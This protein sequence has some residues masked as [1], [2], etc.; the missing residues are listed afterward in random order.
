MADEDEEME[1]VNEEEEAE[2]EM[3]FALTPADAK[4]GI[5]DFSK[6]SGERYYDRATRQL[7]IDD[8]L[9]DVETEDLHG[10]VNA[11][12]ER[13]EEFGWLQIGAGILQIPDD[14]LHPVEGTPTNLITNYGEISMTDL[15]AWENTY[16]TT[17]T[18][19]AQDT[20]M[21]YHC[22]M[23]SLTQA[24]KDKIMLWKS[25]FMIGR[26]R[27]GVLLFKL[28]VRESH[29]DSNATASTIRRQM[30]NLP[31]YMVSVGSDVQK[32]TRH[33]K[34][35]EQGLAARGEASTDLLVN[36]FTG[37]KAAEDDIFHKYVCDKEALHEEG[38]DYSSN[39]LMH[40]MLEKY[41]IIVSK[42]EWMAPTADQQKI[43][44]LESKVS[45]LVKKN[46]TDKKVI[47]KNRNGGKGNPKITQKPSWLV[48]DQKPP[49]DAMDQLRKWNG[50]DWWY[51]DKETGG[52]CPGKWRRHKPSDCQGLSRN[53]HAKKREG[54]QHSD[55][56]KKAKFESKRKKKLAEAMAAEAAK[57][58][59]DASDSD[60]D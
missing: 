5:I 25:E 23:N 60:E 12:G 41:K 3:P 50:L 52:K 47:D 13:A 7:A 16:I 46:K 8:E 2:E 59:E 17:N 32:F 6:R 31:S 39:Q 51:C 26:V 14:P 29:I 58:N 21:L 40:L 27:S 43:V 56:K 42:N 28:I 35:L 11:V 55:K 34:M 19:A 10:F 44:A 24:G 15:R 48:K 18:R 54:D 9:F 33:V 45:T 57:A 49:A 36:L 53:Q 38:K 20:S 22:L 4:Q 30:A 1:E 37:Y